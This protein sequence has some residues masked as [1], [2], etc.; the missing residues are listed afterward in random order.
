MPPPTAIEFDRVGYVQPSGV[1]VLD[2]LTLDIRRGEVMALVGRS[3]AGKTTVLRLINRLALP[4][5]GR[6]LVGGRD[7]L[8]WDP[9]ALRRSIGYVIQ[10]VGLFPHMTVAGNVGVVPRLERWEPARIAARVAELL[11]LVGLTAEHGDRW[12]A[13]LPVDSGSALAWRGRLPPIPRCC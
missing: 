2:A 7:T 8:E 4:Q 9:I 5:Q 3:G 11:E 10:D 6:V 13:E 1:P 12:P